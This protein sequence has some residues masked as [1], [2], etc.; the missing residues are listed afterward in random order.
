VAEYVTVTLQME[1][2]G[3]GSGWTTV[4]P[5]ART[6]VPIRFRYGIEGS[7]LEDRVASPGSLT[8]ALDNS[9]AN[10]GGLLGYYAPGHVNCRSGF[11]LGINVRLKLTYGGTDYYKFH[12][13]LSNIQPIAGQYGSRM[14]LCTAFD[15]MD[16][17]SRGKLKRVAIQVS[18]RADQILTTLVTAMPRQPVSTTFGT[19]LDTYVFALDHSP[20]EGAG[21]L[22]EFQRIA[23]SEVGNIYIKGNTT[24][25]GELVFES[26]TD[27]A[28]KNSNLATFDNSMSELLVSRSRD[29]IVSRLQVVTH[30]KRK[31]TTNVVLFTL[32]DPNVSSDSAIGLGA[33]EAKTIVCPYTNPSSRFERIGAVSTSCVAPV[34]TTDY[35]FFANADGSGTDLTASLGVATTFGATAAFVTLTNNHAT[36]AGFVTFFQLRGPGIYD[37]QDVI[38][39]RTSSTA[40]AAFG[41]QT[42]TFD[43]P[44][45]SDP[46]VGQGASQYFLALLEAQTT[47]VDGISIPASASSTLMT[48]ALA[49]EPGDRIG[50]AEAAS[51]LATT[52]GFFIQSCQGTVLP[53][54]ILEMR[55][56]LAPASYQVFWLLGN[57]GSSELGATTLLGF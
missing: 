27:R 35:T 28:G 37:E 44:Y 22:Q 20:E 46:D 12:G 56:G 21:V 18:K 25:G 34:A 7:R 17:A 16:E 49:R 4:S 23:K 38:S 52:T 32:R 2:S 42:Y 11:A 30:P 45:Q 50:L 40:E 33:G 51:G 24:A 6:Q 29:D 41:E 10:S 1:F 53:R 14:T 19:G 47:T 55:W 36:T 39:E 54:G 48:Q 31:D 13:R 15:W 9:A 3:A 43:M 26:R 8:F 5:D 57:T